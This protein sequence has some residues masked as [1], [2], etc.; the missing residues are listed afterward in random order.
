MKLDE[1][2][3]QAKND[4]LR[5]AVGYLQGCLRLKNIENDATTLRL[6]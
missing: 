4:E 5:K 1:K 2:T 6:V 3:L